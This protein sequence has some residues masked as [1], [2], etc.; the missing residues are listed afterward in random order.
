M[1]RILLQIHLIRSTTKHTNRSKIQSTQTKETKFFLI[2]SISI[3]QISFLK[4]TENYRIFMKEV[5]MA[6]Q[7]KEICAYELEKLILSK[8]L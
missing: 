1:Q 4:I 7:R 8:Y 3:F 5:E 6:N 2:F